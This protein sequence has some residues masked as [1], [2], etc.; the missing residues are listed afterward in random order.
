MRHLLSLPSA[1]LQI[2]SLCLSTIKKD[3]AIEVTNKKFECPPMYNQ[4]GMLSAAI[5]EPRQTYLVIATT[6]MNRAPEKTQETGEMAKK[7]P[8]LVATPFPPFR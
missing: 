7:T 6:R 4:T 3:I 1:N 2:L 5:I 8:R